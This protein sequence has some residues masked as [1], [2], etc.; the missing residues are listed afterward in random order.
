[1]QVI[2]NIPFARVL[3]TC[4]TKGNPLIAL[5]ILGKYVLFKEPDSRDP[6]EQM[7]EVESLGSYLPGRVSDLLGQLMLKSYRMTE[8]G[9]S[10]SSS[11]H[12]GREVSTY[13]S[14]ASE[15]LDYS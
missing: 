14:P 11:S 2:V 7:A 4:D 3:L 9:W 13:S 8:E 1:M 6:E 15:E 12:T 5:D 10:I